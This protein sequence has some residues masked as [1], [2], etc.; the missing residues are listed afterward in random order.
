MFLNFTH[1]LEKLVHIG[2]LVTEIQ[3]VSE[4]VFPILYNTDLFEKYEQHKKEIINRAVL[5]IHF[6]S[7]FKILSKSMQWVKS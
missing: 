3:S 6:I 2:P 7:G 1:V 5:F 4:I